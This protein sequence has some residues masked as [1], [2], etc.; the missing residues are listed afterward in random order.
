MTRNNMI[1]TVLWKPLF[2]GIISELVPNHSCCY[3]CFSLTNCLHRS[4][5]QVWKE[6]VKKKKKKYHLLKMKIIGLLVC[7]TNKVQYENLV[8]KQAMLTRFHTLDS[9]SLPVKSDLLSCCVIQS[10]HFKPNIFLYFSL[11]FP[12]NSISVWVGARHC[13]GRSYFM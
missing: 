1:W 10:S 2:R 9:Y 4:V 11:S 3:H 7:K 5:L 6:K 8:W 12:F 13:I